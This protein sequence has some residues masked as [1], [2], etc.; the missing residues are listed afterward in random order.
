MSTSDSL[1]TRSFSCRLLWSE[2]ESD[3]P[4]GTEQCLRLISHPPDPSVADCCGQKMNLMTRLAQSNVYVW[5]VIHQILQLQIAVVRRWIWWPAWHRAMSTSDSSSTRSFSCRL[6]WSKDE[7]DDRLGTEQCLR[8]IRYPPDPS[9]AD[10]CGQKMNLMTRLAQSNVYV[11]FV[12]YQIFQLQIAVV[13]G[14]IWWPAWHRAM[15]TSDSLSTRSFSCR[16]LWSEDESDD[17]LGTEQC[18]RLISHPPDPSVADCC[19]QKMNLMTRLAQ[20]NVYVW[21]VI[22]QILQLQIAVVKGWIWWPA[23]HRAMSTSD[24][25]STISFSCRLL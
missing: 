20:S 23:W 18:L 21:F 3:D 19:G 15:S 17:P 14:W 1:S 8:L 13:K 10:C 9:A 5:L 16:L 11:W 22:H 7:S 6:L 24:T 25:S 4:L 12:I 2:D